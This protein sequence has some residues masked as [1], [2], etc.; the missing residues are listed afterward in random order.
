MIIG[1]LISSCQ[2]NSNNEVDNSSRIQSFYENSKKNYGTGNMYEALEAAEKGIDLA[3]RSGNANLTVEGILHMQRTYGYL[4][5]YKQGIALSKS[6]QNEIKSCTNKQILTSLH[7][8]IGILEANLKNYANAKTN[9]LK[10]IELTKEAG[11]FESLA[12]SYINL[13][14]LQFRTKDLSGA[15]FYYDQSEKYLD[16]STPEKAKIYRLYIKV[17]RTAL[18]KENGEIESALKQFEE[19][20]NVV[21]SEEVNDPSLISWV[22]MEYLE[23]LF[24]AKQYNRVL[25][26]GSTYINESNVKSGDYVI[27]QFYEL[28]LEVCE[29]LDLKQEHI[30]FLENFLQIKN[31][32]NTLSLQRTQ[33][34]SQIIKR[35]EKQAIK[36]E[37]EKALA[38]EKSKNQQLLL[39]TSVLGIISILLVTLHIFNRY[40]KSQDKNRRL[41]KESVELNQELEH[42]NSVITSKILQLSQQQGFISTLKDELDSESDEKGMIEKRIIIRRLNELNGKR[43]QNLWAE[44]EAVFENLHTGFFDNLLQDHPKLTPNERKL[45]SFTRLNLSTQE[46]SEITGQSPNSIKIARTRLRKKLGLTHSDVTLYEFI[47]KY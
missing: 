28:V 18:Q 7:N 46:I 25:E 23:S 44:F 21:Q 20:L 17:G 4:G 38:E 47:S 2:N 39:I 1:V 34:K 41:K 42:R 12:S 30:D 35:I 16:N 26:L 14:R 29:K 3:Q 33:R 13:A 32:L 43:N 6:Y 37:K 22:K 45:C 40:K 11:K 8:N 24:L 9:Y 27:I 10:A 19:V 15:S 31:E 5:M 36:S